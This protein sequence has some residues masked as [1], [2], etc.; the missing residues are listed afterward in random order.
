MEELIKFG[1]TGT[2]AEVVVVVACLFFVVVVVV[3]VLTIAHVVHL[4]N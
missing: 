3:V 4:H 2:L 1:T